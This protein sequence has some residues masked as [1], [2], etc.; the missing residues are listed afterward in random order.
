M[1]SKHFDGFL[2]LSKPATI[3]TPTTDVPIDL[4]LTT[5]QPTHRPLIHRPVSW[6]F[7]IYVKI[8]DHIPKI[9]CIL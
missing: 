6:L 5:Y 7:P 2:V 1:A 8:E 3:N 9:F 4:L